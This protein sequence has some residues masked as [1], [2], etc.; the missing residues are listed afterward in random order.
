[1]PEGQLCYLYA[2]A[3]EDRITFD[4]ETGGPTLDGSCEGPFKFISTASVNDNDLLTE[5]V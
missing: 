1:M 3:D 5:A 2:G 4:K